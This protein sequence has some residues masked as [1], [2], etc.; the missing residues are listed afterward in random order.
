MTALIEE[1]VEEVQ[2][3]SL[4]LK[5]LPE[6]R[7]VAISLGYSFVE[8]SNDK[9]G[10]CFTPRSI[11]ASCTHYHKAG[12]LTN[13]NILE[14][15]ELMLSE[16]PLEKSIGVAV[17]NV[18]S[19]MIMDNLPEKYRFEEGNFL[20]LLP[21]D[22]QSSKVGMIGNIEPFIPFLVKHSSSLVVV[23]DNPSLNPGVQEKGYCISRNMQD[24]ADADIVI[25]T[26]SSVVV[27]DFD[28]AVEAAKTA[29]FIGVVG[30]SAGWLPDPAFR[31]GINVVAGTKIT[32]ITRARHVIL[33]GGGTPN[34][35]KYGL[36]YMIKRKTL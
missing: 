25:M 29:R 5:V 21:I 36:K 13:K 8:L 23:D 7:M 31:R 30:P 10:I 27:G 33:E 6:I 2:K 24:L 19:Q 14:L 34:F 3:R 22:H 9:M 11:N 16:H 1:I 4:I 15:A 28:R 18:L 12:T 32:D 17:V 20:D 35:S 26:G